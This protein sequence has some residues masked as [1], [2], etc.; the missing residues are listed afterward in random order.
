MFKSLRNRK[1]FM[2]PVTWAVLGI[3]YMT[4]AFWLIV[5]KMSQ[6]AGGT[7]EKWF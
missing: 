5:L 4:A 1:G 7:V 3:A 2:E 6:D